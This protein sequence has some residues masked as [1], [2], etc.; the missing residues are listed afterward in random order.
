MSERYQW[1]MKKKQRYIAFIIEGS[2]TDRKSMI[3]YIRENFSYEEY[4]DISPWLT[5]FTGDKG[6][7]RCDHDQKNKAVE[8]LNSIKIDDG[9]VRTITTSGTI[10]KAKKRLFEDG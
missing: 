9:N 10:K 4:Q 6:I 2:S 7:I 8:I 5:V 1:L 3:A